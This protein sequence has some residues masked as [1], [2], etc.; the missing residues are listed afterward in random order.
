VTFKFC[1]LPLLCVLVNLLLICSFIRFVP[2]ADQIPILFDMFVLISLG[3]TWSSRFCS[4]P[5]L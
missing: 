3:S 4:N 5:L 2:F 1:A